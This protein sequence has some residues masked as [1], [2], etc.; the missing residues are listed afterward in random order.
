MADSGSSLVE[1]STPPMLMRGVT[2]SSV[3]LGVAAGPGGATVS[4][5]GSGR[6]TA[7]RYGWRV[8]GSYTNSGGDI[9]WNASVVSRQGGDREKNKLVINKIK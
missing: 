5:G 4:V 3:G 6:A 8:S 7:P 1:D 2:G 9:M